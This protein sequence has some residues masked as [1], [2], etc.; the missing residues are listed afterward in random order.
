MKKILVVV[1]AL[2]AMSA[3]AA[4]GEAMNM[5]TTAAAPAAK[6]VVKKHKKAKKA[7][8]GKKGKKAAAAAEGNGA[9]AAP[10]NPPA[11]Q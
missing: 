2:F 5:N 6:T 9:A 8:K 7:K 1:A 4:E 10:V 11:G 3:F